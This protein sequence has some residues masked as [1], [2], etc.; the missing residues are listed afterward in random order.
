VDHC[1]FLLRTFLVVILHVYPKAHLQS[2]AMPLEFVIRQHIRHFMKLHIEN[3]IDLL[4]NTA[5][6]TVAVVRLI[7]SLMESFVHK[8]RMRYGDGFQ[9]NH[10]FIFLLWQTCSAASYCNGVGSA[11]PP[12]QP[13]PSCGMY[14]S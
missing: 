9:I 13:L 14:K 7:S 5:Q 11:C 3:A 8:N 10:L 1:A 4:I 6:V 2:V 12:Q